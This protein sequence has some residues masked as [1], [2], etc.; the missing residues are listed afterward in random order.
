MKRSRQRDAQPDANRA[1]DLIDFDRRLK[2]LTR[3]TP[4]TG[5]L[6]S[7]NV[8]MWLAMVWQG[9]DWL[10]PSD[11]ALTSW[12]ANGPLAAEG[13]G[14]RL[15]AAFFLHQGL[16]Q[17][18]FNQWALYQLGTLLERLVGH[19]GLALIYLVSGFAAGLGS[20]LARPDAVTAGSTPAIAGL[21]GA[22]IAYHFRVRGA[23]PPGVLS[24]LR[25]S[26]F[27]FLA[28][29]IGYGIF[30]QRMD[31]AGFLA[32][33]AAGLL[34]GW[35]TAL[36]LGEGRGYRRML[37]NALLAAGGAAL[38]F[39]AAFV[40]RPTALGAEIA[41]YRE[42]NGRS[43]GIYAEA[44]ERLAADRIRPE[45]F[46]KIIEREVLPDWQE[47]EKRFHDL[48]DVP[49][50]AAPLL[51][52]IERSM[53]LRAQTWRLEIEVL[54]TGDE[55]DQTHE[56]SIRIIDAF[57]AAQNRYREEKLSLENFLALIERETLPQLASV[58]KRLGEW[59]DVPEAFETPLETWRRA[60]ELRER[61][62]KLLV[63]SLRAQVGDER[64]AQPEIVKLWRQADD[65]ESDLSGAVKRA[66]K[67]ALSTVA[68]KAEEA[69]KLEGEFL[70][71]IGRLR[72][73]PE[74]KPQND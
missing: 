65:L 46:V 31:N 57:V 24:R 40:V 15:L 25:P 29:N 61:A 60:L 48:K 72:D 9:A 6:L 39:F 14:W 17:L 20:F 7:V 1:Q 41:R 51:K 16:M 44:S 28:W 36:P 70:E 43:L 26:V 42:V 68:A 45:Q 54:A 67:E 23:L 13:E 59:T 19:V 34:C 32:G 37:R 71:G 62:L 53:D 49:E 38:A 12:G 52:T 8:V 73:A 64:A 3:V 27:V 11:D 66:S 56:I 21:L 63:E 69:A 5:A 4:V 2:A 18:I 50:Q 35:V 10:E 58:Q 74:R 47:Q 33:L 55:I 30:R 22:I